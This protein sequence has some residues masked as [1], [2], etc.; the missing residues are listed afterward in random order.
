MIINMI[1]AAT[2]EGI[3]G[4]KGALPWEDEDNDLKEDLLRF[5]KLTAN[6][7]VIMGAGT[8]KSLLAKNGKLL[9]KRLNI[10]I[11]GNHTE[12][13]ARELMELELPNAFV[14]S[15]L[16][17]AYI[18]ANELS[19]KWGNT[20]WVIGGAKIYKEAFELGGLSNV[21]L[22]RIHRNY[23]GDTCVSLSRLKDKKWSL[24]DL[25]YF[26]DKNPKFSYERYENERL[27]PDIYK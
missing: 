18:L 26:G 16:E 3:I 8:M 7:I 1:L 23:E 22:T 21:F 25:E 11:S 20:A 15:S 4:N 27:V 5:R 10:I 17:D 19:P 24:M 6:Q 13:I 12:E 2:D 14:V 9:P